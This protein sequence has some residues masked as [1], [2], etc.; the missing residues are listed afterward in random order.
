MKYKKSFGFEKPEHFV[1]E[2]LKGIHKMRERFIELEKTLKK[3]FPLSRYYFV[4]RKQNRKPKNQRYHERKAKLINRIFSTENSFFS[5]SINCCFYIK[6][7]KL[8]GSFF[9]PIKKRY[10]ISFNLGSAAT[11]KHKRGLVHINLR[12]HNFIYLHKRIPATAP[13]LLVYFI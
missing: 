7:V 9:Q 6:T 1:S 4:A 5:C 13:P 3:G 2:I 11:S 10:D 12:V 8:D